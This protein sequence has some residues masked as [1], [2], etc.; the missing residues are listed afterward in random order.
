[1]SVS[2]EQP[3]ARRATDIHLAPIA[4]DLVMSKNILDDALADAAKGGRRVAHASGA[5]PEQDVIMEKLAKYILATG[6]FTLACTILSV[7][8]ALSRLSRTL[9]S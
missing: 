3:R 5:V 4:S 9:L 7:V 8:I 1:M 6:V 2:P